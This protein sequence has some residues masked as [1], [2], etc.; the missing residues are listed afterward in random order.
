MEIPPI[1]DFS[2]V[3]VLSLYKHP[4][5]VCAPPGLVD[6]CKTLEEREGVGGH[7]DKLQLRNTMKVNKMNN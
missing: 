5:G 4:F 6:L 7:A 3:N 2:S 1:L